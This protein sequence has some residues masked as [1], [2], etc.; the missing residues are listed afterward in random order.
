MSSLKNV[1]KYSYLCNCAKVTTSFM[2]YNLSA[3][4]GETELQLFCYARIPDSCLT[5]LILKPIG[6][7]AQCRMTQVFSKKT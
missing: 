3:K 7:L 4:V 2:L 1:P 5:L 6:V